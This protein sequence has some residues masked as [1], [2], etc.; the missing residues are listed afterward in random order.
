VKLSEA[1]IGYGGYSADF[2]HPGDRRRF[3]AYAEQK[4]IEFEAA[5]LDR[6]YD[7]V[8]ATHNADL[9]GWT[10]RKRRRGD[11]KFVF[12]LVDS[13]FVQHVTKLPRLMKGTARRL[14]GM[15]SRLSADFMRTLITTCEAADAVICATPEQRAMIERYNPNIT[16]SF[17]YFGG[18]LDPPKTDYSRSGKLR[19][20]WEGQSTTLFNVNVIRDVLNEFRDEVELHVVTDPIVHRHFG[21]F[22]RHPSADVL[23][24]INCEKHFYPW[25]KGSFSSHLKQADVA[26]IPIWPDH[27]MSNAKP[28]NKL[29]LL[30][31][32]GMPVLTSATPAYVRTMGNAG[33][34]MACAGLDEWRAALRRM[35]AASPAELEAIA[36]QGQRHAA[37]AYSQA[38]FQAR[39][40]AAF[41]SVGFEPA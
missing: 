21:R 15:E 6:P 31:Q 32:L 3:G 5:R 18:D 7:L 27:R 8:L 1:R 35:I 37:T 10:H 9:T 33:L 19:L 29:V 41:A 30:W 23:A 25:E 2:L 12:E 28:E 36:L 38:E 4:G 11:F 13:Y 26:I 22:G 34:D 17:D 40:D 39:F 24:E 16:M 20:G 14:M